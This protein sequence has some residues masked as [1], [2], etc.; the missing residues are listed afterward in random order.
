MLVLLIACA[1]VAS[2]LLTRAEG[3]RREIA[4]RQALGASRWR[5]ARQVLCE[6]GVLALLATFVALVFAALAIRLL[7]AIVIPPSTHASGWQVVLDVRVVAFMIAAAILTA[8]ACSAGPA[9][10]A[11]HAS[12]A[13]AM[14]SER[15]PGGRLRLPVRN[16]L[17]V[18]QVALAVVTL[19]TAGL[20]LRAF[21]E[22]SEV[23][24]GFDRKDMP[25]A[26]A[27]DQ[28]G[29][30]R[31]GL[32]PHAWHARPAGSRR[33][34]LRIKG[35]GLFLSVVRRG[36]VLAAEVLLAKDFGQWCDGVRKC[37]GV[38]RH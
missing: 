28:G 31:R 18:G 15:A 17:V 35:R 10:S 26:H 9:L 7:P 20:L 2:L 1:N 4:I 8:L 21:M 34:P 11:S 6:G 36:S 29:R 13:L 38:V 25:L 33:A 22:A 14:G 27:A 5:I 30:D 23:H 24:L 19:A 3:R 37:G 16:A 12:L 32:L